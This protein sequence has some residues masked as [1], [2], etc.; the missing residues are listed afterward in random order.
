MSISCLFKFKYV[1]Q[2]WWSWV[3]QVNVDKPLRESHAP[4]H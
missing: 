1:I 2:N 3:Q 4:L